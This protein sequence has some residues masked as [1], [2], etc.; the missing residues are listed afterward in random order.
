MIQATDLAQILNGG[1]YSRKKR[2]PRKILIWPPFFKMAAMGI[3]KCY[4]C[5]KMAVDGQK[6]YCDNSV[7]GL[8]MQN[9]Q[10]MW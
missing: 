7:Y 9:V 1:H 3:L 4:F 8:R 5:L 6:D 10:F 2:G